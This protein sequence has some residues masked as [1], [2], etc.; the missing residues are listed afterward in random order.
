MRSYDAAIV[1]VYP[2]AFFNETVLY[3][4]G[5]SPTLSKAITAEDSLLLRVT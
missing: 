5:G 1:T 3:A 4:P 2:G